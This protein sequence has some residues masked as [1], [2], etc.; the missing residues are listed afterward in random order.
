MLNAYAELKRTVCKNVDMNAIIESE[1]K[2]V[3]EMK[4]T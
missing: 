4:I 2:M 3:E 1:C